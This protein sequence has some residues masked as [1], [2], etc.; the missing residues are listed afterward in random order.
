MLGLQPVPARELLDARG[1]ADQGEEPD[2]CEHQIAGLQA[3]ADSCPAW[4]ASQCQP[5]EA[6]AEH[7]DDR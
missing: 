1:P 4:L 3:P 6:E 2:G 7:G 5:W